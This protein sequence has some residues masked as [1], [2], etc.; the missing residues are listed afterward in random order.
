MIVGREKEREILEEAFKKDASRFVAVYGRR[1]VG[2][3]FL[4]R[5]TFGNR[6]TFQHAGLADG[7]IR[8]EI[9]QFCISLKRAGL[10]EL[11]KPKNWMEAFE[12]LKDLIE[13]SAEEKKVIFIDEL[14]WM[15]TPKSK[16]IMALESFWNGWA[17]GR[18][19]I[20]LIICSSAT[21]WIIKR[22]FTIKA[23]CI[24]A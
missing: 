20:L 5:E 4:V 24:I 18:K 19:D 2:K 14:S 15:D 3:T 22:F 12:L 17:S 8:E 10:K 6:F 11:K 1:R 9:D 13:Q 16:L 7:K 21:S 23:V